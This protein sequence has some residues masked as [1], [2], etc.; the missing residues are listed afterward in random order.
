M[1]I[2]FIFFFF[3]QVLLAEAAAPITHLTVAEEFLTRCTSDASQKMAFL[4]GTLFPDICYFANIPKEETHEKVIALKDVLISPSPFI[5]G[6]RLHF[7]LDEIRESLAVKWKLYSWIQEFEA[8]NPSTLLKFVEDE[9]LFDEIDSQ[10]FS[11]SLDSI[12]EEELMRGIP[13]ETVKNWHLLLKTYIAKR[14]SKALSELSQ[15]GLSL[16]HIPSTVLRSWSQLLPWLSNQELLKNYLRELKVH[17]SFLLTAFYSKKF[18]LAPIRPLPLV[19]VA[20]TE[21]CL[22]SYI[23]DFRGK[24]SLLKQIKDRSPD[25][26]FLLVIDALC[27]FLAKEQHIPMNYVTLIPANMPFSAKRFPNRPASLHSIARGIP[28]STSPPWPEFTLHQRQRKDNSLWYKKFGPLSKEDT[29]LTKLVIAHMSLHKDLPLIAALDTF[30]GNTDR[31]DPNLFYDKETDSFCGIDMAAGFN[32][33]LGKPACSQLHRLFQS[34]LKAQE[35]RSLSLYRDTLQS[36][37]SHYPVEKLCSLLDTFAQT[38]G[39]FEGSPWYTQEVQE[40]IHHH[41]KMIEEN[42]KSCLDLLI[43]LDYYLKR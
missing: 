30:T 37:L 12:L 3:W 18:A 20:E 34:D 38:A 13:W 23:K 39:F 27:C 26:Q 15:K 7:L 31:S 16:F 11:C 41:K 9:I 6:M 42:S 33:N 25:E 40:R 21:D 17:F 2:G 43:I 32:T 19:Q 24:K 1:R 22:I 8:Q 35:L 36:L 5:A 29:G 14:P 4:L 10:G 28:V